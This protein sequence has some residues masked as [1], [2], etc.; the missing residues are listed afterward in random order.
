M[1]VE[2][3]VSPC[4]PPKIENRKNAKMFFPLYL[5]EG[6]FKISELY[7]KFSP[8]YFCKTA[9]LQKSV[10]KAS[11]LKISTFKIEILKIAEN[12]F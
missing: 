7:I 6:I 8:R 12:G 11:F 5:Q 1:G 2:N 9:E 3:F 4:T 10:L